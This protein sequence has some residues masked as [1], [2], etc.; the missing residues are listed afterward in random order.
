VGW[1][2][3]W[4]TQACSSVCAGPSWQTFHRTAGPA[5]AHSCCARNQ[6]RYLQLYKK[7][8]LYKMIKFTFF[9]TIKL[10]SMSFILKF[11]HIYGQDIIII[12]HCFL[13]YLDQYC[14]HRLLDPDWCFHA[15]FL[16]DE[17]VYHSETCQFLLQLCI[18]KHIGDSRIR[19]LI[20]FE[21]I[22]LHLISNIYLQICIFP[23]K[24]YNASYGLILAWRYNVNKLEYKLRTDACL[25]LWYLVPQ[26]FLTRRF[27]KI[28]ILTYTTW[29]TLAVCQSTR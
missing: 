4:R 21:H 13:L 9:T 27:L 19:T 14:P 1:G 12:L 18:K 3:E 16:R 23:C 28:L 7:Q 20:S 8:A 25:P 6:L 11:F 22:L 29:T 10:R 24:T 5:A 26:L 2:F 15:H 17:L